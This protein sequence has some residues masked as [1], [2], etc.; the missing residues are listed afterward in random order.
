MVKSQAISITAYEIVFDPT[1]AG[2]L[3]GKFDTMFA[4]WSGIEIKALWSYH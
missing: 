2:G 4:G 1:Q 3:L